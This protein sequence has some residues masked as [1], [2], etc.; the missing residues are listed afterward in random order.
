MLR[1]LW[2]HGGQRNVLLL[3][4]LFGLL[5][6]LVRGDGGGGER[7]VGVHPLGV[8]VQVALGGEVLVTH[9][10]REAAAVST[11]ATSHLQ[12]EQEQKVLN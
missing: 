5:G 1:V 10:A 6:D 4:L 12:K 7:R 2:K 11:I 8:V 9:G 3:L